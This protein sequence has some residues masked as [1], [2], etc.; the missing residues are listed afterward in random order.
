MSIIIMYYDTHTH[1]HARAHTHTHA[2]A[3]THTH[4]HTH[5]PSSEIRNELPLQAIIVLGLEPSAGASRG[6]GMTRTNFPGTRV[7]DIIT[8]EVFIVTGI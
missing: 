5:T 8:D 4:T 2:R 3:H 7:V 6:T 1:T